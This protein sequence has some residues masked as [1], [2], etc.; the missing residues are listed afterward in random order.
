MSS[1]EGKSCKVEDNGKDYLKDIPIVQVYSPEQWHGEQAIVMNEKGRDALVS[2]LVS[3]QYVIPV[4]CSDGEGGYL[5]LITEPT[6]EMI[7]QY[8]KPYT[9]KVARDSS[10]SIEDPRL[11]LT[12]EEHD[13]IQKGEHALV[14]A[15]EYKHVVKISIKEYLDWRFA[16]ASDAE[17]AFDFIGSFM[18]YGWKGIQNEYRTI[19]DL[20]KNGAGHSYLPDYIFTEGFEEAQRLC[21]GDDITNL[22]PDS[23]EAASIA[24]VWEE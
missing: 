6:T 1:K 18:Q 10:R 9:W 8:H 3:K 12:K 16:S 5:L 14:R 19:E 20:G 24:F 11:S 23:G 4:F 13:L 21:S 2:A 22:Y 15:P 7:D 17:D